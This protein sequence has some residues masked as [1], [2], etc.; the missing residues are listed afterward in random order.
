MRPNIIFYFSDQQRWDTVNE[1]ATPNLMQLAREGIQFENSYTCQP[2][3]GPARAC[4]QTGMYA[5]QC[6]C[7][8]NGVPL[9]QTIRPMAEYFN[10]AG[11]ETAYVGKWHLASDRLPNVGFHCEK[12]AIPKE[13]QGG[14]KNWWRAADVLEFTSH[15]Y[16]GYVFDAEGNQ[17][18]FKG[19]R[20]DCIND[21]ALEYL[22]QKTSDDPFFLFISQLE[23]H[24]QNDRHC[25]E[26][27]KETVEKFRDYPIPP[28]LS[29]LEG[30]YEKM[31]PDYMAAINRLDENVGRLVA[32][33]KEKGLY[34]NTILIY[35]S[36]HGSHFKTRNLEYKRSCHDSATHTPLI[37]R[38]GPFQGGKK[39][40]RLVSLIDLPPTMLDLAGIPIPKSYMGHSL[41]RELA[42]EEPERDCVFI[43]ISES[44]CGRA[45]RTKQYKYSV[46]ALAPTGY[47]I[48]R[49][50]VYFEDYLYDLTKDPIEKNNLIKDRSY[51]F[52]RQKMKKL[53]LRE[54]ERAG[55]KKPV[56]L[57]A[58]RS[59]NK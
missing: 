9:P 30:D 51:A 36:D 25:Y 42:G 3:C 43:Q 40:E 6:G 54:M 12:T 50:P 39:E 38:G 18:D 24:H 48:H 23:P 57:P 46:R 22:D 1:E 32:K 10:E 7:Y 35:T 27:P 4:L 2:V 16:D 52:V 47:T 45:I 58:Y 31:Y 53:L 15:G 34:E 8:W 41:V 14:Y 29:F 13:R 28:D 56:I 5:T 33:L 17:I 19:Y 37:I 44:Q 21:F 20:A 49:S 11:Y 26:G 59:R 55:E